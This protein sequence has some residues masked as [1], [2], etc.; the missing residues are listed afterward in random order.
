MNRHK[1]IKNETVCNLGPCVAGS[2]NS[3]VPLQR[4]PDQEVQL[5]CQTMENASCH[6]QAGHSGQQSYKYAKIIE[7]RIG[8]LTKKT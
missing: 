4:P 8:H 2:W 3:C 1:I 7:H 6:L 5:A